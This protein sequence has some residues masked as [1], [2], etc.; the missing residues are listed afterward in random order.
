MTTI[1]I[2]KN[3]AF[4]RENKTKSNHRNLFRLFKSHKITVQVLR[5]ELRIIEL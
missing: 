4:I 5:L 3:K 2:I 1:F